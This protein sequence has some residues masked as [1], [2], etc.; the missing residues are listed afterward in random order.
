MKTRRGFSK[1]FIVCVSLLSLFLIPTSSLGATFCVSNASELQTAL[2]TAESNG[3]N[4]TIK[5]VQGTY[6]GNFT[7]ASTEAYG[8]TVEGGYT[9]D[10]ASR[11]IDPAN[12][13]LDGGGTDTVLALVSQGSA[14]FSV[15][16]LTFQNGNASTTDDG[17]GLYAKTEDGN[18]IVTNNTFTGNTANRSGG[19]VYVYYSTTG[20]TVT[21]C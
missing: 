9:Q 5:I 12:T 15:E 8:L 19:G 20:S 21:N 16:G 18:V 14:T 1:G 2:T 10:C 13:I 6:N 11:T 7:Y 4:N 17:G 3:E